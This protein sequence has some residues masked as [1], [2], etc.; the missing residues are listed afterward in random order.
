MKPVEKSHPH[1][2]VLLEPAWTPQTWREIAQAVGCLGL[3]LVI[4]IM[5][6]CL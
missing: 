4:V 2:N 6:M 3:A 5:V 1:A